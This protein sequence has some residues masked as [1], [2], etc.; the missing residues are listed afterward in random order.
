MAQNVMTQISSRHPASILSVKAWDED[1]FALAGE[2]FALERT[3][4]A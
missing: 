1:L 3:F 4:C 2:R